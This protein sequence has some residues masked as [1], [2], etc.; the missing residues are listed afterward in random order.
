MSNIARKLP[1]AQAREDGTLRYDA[2]VIGAGQAGGPL[3]GALAKAGKRVALIERE[4]VGGTCVNVGCTPTKTMVASAAAAELAR[5]GAEYGVNTGPV[6]VD[7]ERVRARKRGIVESF[8]DGSRGSLERIERL[9]LIFGSASFTGPRRIEVVSGEGRLVVTADE[10]IINVGTR[11]SVLQVPGIETVDPLD[12]TSIMELE[13]LPRRLL[14]VGGGYVG[15]EFAQ[16]FRRFGS[17]VA[18]MQQ[19]A[20]LLMREDDDVATALEEILIDDGIDVMTD[21]RVLSAAPTGDGV[22]LTVRVGDEER[23]I[24]GSHLLAAVG[25]RPNTD[26]LGLASAG[27]RMDDR[28][29]ITVDDQL[30]TSAEGVWA[31]GDVNGGP[32]FTHISYDDYR[33]VRD[34]LL[35]GVE[36]RVTGRQIP[37]T[38]YSDPQLGRVGLTERE[39][40]ATGRRIAV[41]R[42]PAK[43]AARAI[44]TGN[45]RGLWKAVVDIDTEEIL[46]AAILGHE[47]GEVMSVVQV[48]MM[49]GLS[50]KA[51]RDG[52]FA[53]P[54]YAESLNNLFMTLGQD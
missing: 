1:N 41:A 6:E 35:K 49:G 28:G 45:I 8:R 33:I 30:Q 37:Y 4:H 38:V 48:A 7:L 43:R 29:Y 15:V 10:V 46:G 19:G 42:M 26:G 50:Y 44:E 14:V 34:R 13:K 25:R 39:A 24:T 16:M 36:R 9:D 21:A 20:Q 17:E 11:P 53:H 31:L 52:V 27:V 3:A 18:L 54:T 40:Q 5:R 51:L 32:A 23:R 2:L 47:G 22:E 12:S